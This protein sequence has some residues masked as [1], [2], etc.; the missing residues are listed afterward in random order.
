MTLVFFATG[1]AAGACAIAGAQTAA[2]WGTL[3]DALPGAV[4]GSFFGLACGVVSLAYVLPLLRQ[5][6]PRASLGPVFV[7]PA[8][9]LVLA[10]VLGP[11]ALLTA[12][13]M[14][15]LGAIQLRRDSEERRQ[16][17]GKC[18]CGYDTTGVPS[19]ICPECGRKPLPRAVET[20]DSSG[21]AARL[22]CPRC[23]YSLRG[24]TDAECPE[25]GGTSPWVRS[26]RADQAES[27]QPL[28]TALVALLTAVLS[29]LGSVLLFALIHVGWSRITNETG[30]MAKYGVMGGG[31]CGLLSLAWV[32]P[33]LWRVPLRESRLLVF[34]LPGVVGVVLGAVFPLLAAFFAG[35]LQL[36]TS[37]YVY[38]AWRDRQPGTNSRCSTCGYSLRG[39]REPICPECGESVRLADTSPK[40][41]GASGAG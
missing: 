38:A 36:A 15:L 23:G 22:D 9:V 33:A 17:E 31:A 39:L 26:I 10:G 1:F 6:D 29:A 11:L 30:V 32:L 8:L 35:V 41:A 3:A 7:L 16:L 5:V 27:G 37:A 24:L 2:V 28:A 13:V 25:C 19:D 40:R 4:V 18:L 14:Q 20:I 21:N 34:I 12:L